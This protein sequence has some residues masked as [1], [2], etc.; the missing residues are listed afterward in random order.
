MSLS[1]NASEPR[2][3]LHALAA[4]LSEC[5]GR[6]AVGRYANPRTVPDD[7]YT[8]IFDERFLAVEQLRNPPDRT[9]AQ[10]S[11]ICRRANL[12]R[13]CRILDLCCGYGRHAVQLARRGHSV[14][15]VDLSP[16]MLN[17]AELNAR[18]AGVKLDLRLQDARA[19]VNEKFD[20]VISLN[21][22]L[23]YLP[24]LAENEE[25]VASIRRFL[26]PRGRFIFRQIDPTSRR[27]RDHQRRE[28]YLLPDGSLYRK[29]SH[30]CALRRLWWGSYTYMHKNRLTMLPFRIMLLPDACG[31]YGGRYHFRQRGRSR[32]LVDGARR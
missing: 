2:P 8:R 21:T 17:K 31:H 20:L 13:P 12:S 28:A 24:T 18:R 11:Q 25:F 7:W 32:F 29:V 5:Q 15:G 19:P 16:A 23:G 10:V 9:L 22:S 30:F 14:V 26:S 27:T 3:A 1:V 4:P 6:I